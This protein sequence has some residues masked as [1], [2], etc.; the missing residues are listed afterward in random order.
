MHE[1]YCIAL[2]DH[3]SLTEHSPL[4]LP[5]PFPQVP[6]YNCS[7]FSSD[8]PDPF[9][10]LNQVLLTDLVPNTTY[11]MIAG[12]NDFRE[13]WSQVYETTYMPQRPDGSVV[14]A[15]LADFGFVNDESMALLTADALAGGFDYLH[16]IG[17]F[18]YDLDAGVKPGLIGNEFFR[19][20]EPVVSRVPYHP[21]PVSVARLTVVSS[22][23]MPAVSSHSAH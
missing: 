17:D 12:S 20:I 2:I 1:A 23:L 3:A 22:P 21:A 4:P 19:A 16:H 14:Y 7:D 5:F 6:S 8:M 18:A 11:Y 9:S 15:I 13:P 10:F